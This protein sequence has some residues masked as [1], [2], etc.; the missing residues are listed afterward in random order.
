MNEPDIADKFPEIK[1]LP[2]PFLMLD[3]KRVATHSD[4]MRRREEIKELLTRYEYGRMPSAPGKVSAVETA[5][6]VEFYDGAAVQRQLK[7][8]FGSGPQALSVGVN[9]TVPK[10]A[11]PFPVIVRN[12]RILERS[13]ILPENVEAAARRG[14]IVAEYQDSDLQP[15]ETTDLGPARKA[16]PDYDWGT[17]AVWA[18]GGMRVID[19]L[20]TLPEV[21]KDRIVVTGHSRGGKTAL[22]TG[23]L[24]DRVAL[25]VPNA[26][27]SGGFQCWRFPMQPGDPAGVKRHETVKMLCKQFPSWL[28]AAFNAFAQHET[29][30]PF[31][32]HFLAALVAPR[33]LCAT[34]CLDDQCCTP[35]CAQRSYQASKVVFDWLGASDRIGIHFRRQGGH[36]QG[37]EDWAALLDNADFIFSGRKPEGG[38]P[39]N[40]LPYPEAPSGFDW[41]APEDG[42]A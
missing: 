24:D 31:D 4:W 34:E 25:T 13:Q 10:G 18:W 6:G 1:E 38:R 17:I 30:L 42:G 16:Y 12:R 20:E 28:H 32:Q 5:K 23:A 26:T 8:S 33:A 40:T 35:I 29:R 21:R 11:G 9:L 19:F 15:D 2:D 27:G 39:F 36:A 7:L 41:T 3:G 22:L 37:P 14:Y